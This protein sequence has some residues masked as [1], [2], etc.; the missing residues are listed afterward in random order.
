MVIFYC[1]LLVIVLFLVF[2]EIITWPANM[3][4]ILA[5]HS[6]SHAIHVIAYVII[7]N[8]ICFLLRCELYM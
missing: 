8:C 2:M 6:N 7:F 3:N 1:V 4:S 5:D